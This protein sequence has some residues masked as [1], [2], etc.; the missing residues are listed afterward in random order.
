MLCCLESTR[1]LLSKYQ[2]SSVMMK[3]DNV[4]DSH[5]KVSK[6]FDFIH[7]SQQFILDRISCHYNQQRVAILEKIYSCNVLHS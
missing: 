4:I 6:S 3:Y 7:K 2:E 1:T 5:E